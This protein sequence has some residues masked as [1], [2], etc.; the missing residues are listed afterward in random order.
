MPLNL[1]EHK[2]AMKKEKGFSLIELLIVVA[3][4]G[5]IAA[6]AVPNLVRS[7]VVAGWTGG[8]EI[9]IE[10]SQIPLSRQCS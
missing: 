8:L 9:E 10:M 5:V 1:E 6:I 3:V 4:I 2:C 7:K